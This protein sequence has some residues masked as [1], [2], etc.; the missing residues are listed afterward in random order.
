MKLIITVSGKKDAGKTTIANQIAAAWINM[1]PENLSHGYR[2]Y[3][4]DN[5]KLQ[6]GNADIR[7]P[8]TRNSPY[9]VEH[10]LSDPRFTEKVGVRIIAFATPLKEFCIKVLG[11][12]HEQC[13]GTNQQKNSQ[14]K[15]M[16]NGLPLG[17]RMKYR[18][19]WWHRPRRGPMTGR[20][21]MQ[22]FGTDVIRDWH[23]N[24]WAHAGYELAVSI[25]ET[26][27]LLNDSR[28]PNEILEGDEY[29]DSLMNRYVF[30]IRL[31]RNPHP[32]DRHPSEHALDNFPIRWFDLVINADVTHEQQGRLIDEKLQWWLKSV[33]YSDLK[34]AA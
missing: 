12:S 9:S 29:D 2:Y 17:V 11:L 19:L 34:Q 32:E 33:G 28:F 30:R 5:G 16:W 26:L 15:V 31:L 25:P 6:Y 18:R 10:G 3:V 14:T 22:V 20:E 24:A 23:A 1:H 4:D 21:V 8:I 7:V 27:V 13:Y